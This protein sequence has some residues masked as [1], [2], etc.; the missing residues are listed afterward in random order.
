MNGDET[1][2]G[3]ES[4]GAVKRGVAALMRTTVRDRHDSRTYHERIVHNVLAAALDGTCEATVYDGDDTDRPCGSAAIVGYRLDH[5]DDQPWS[6]CAVHAR[7]LVTLR[8][9]LLGGAA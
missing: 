8:A 1:A 9:H 4:T 5:D 7:N 2:G 3:A 6:V